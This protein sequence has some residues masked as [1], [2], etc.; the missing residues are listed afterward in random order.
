MKNIK[1]YFVVHKIQGLIAGVILIYAGYYTYGHFTGTS[2]ETRYTT[3][4]AD[5]QTIV[6][7]VTG[8]GQVSALNQ[9]DIKSK[10]SGDVTYIGVTNGQDVY[11]GQII[12]EL[13]S[14]SA[15]KTVR[16]AQASLDSA[17]L[18]LVKIKEPADAL[19]ILQAEN[20]ITTAKQ[21]QGQITN[22]ISKTYDD[23]F[24]TVSAAFID[25]PT[26]VT[27]LQNILYQNTNNAGQDNVSYYSDLVKNYDANV[28][29][30]RSNA[31]TAYQK[32]RQVYDK[33]FLDYKSSTRYADAAT[34]RNLLDETTAT[35]KA[36]ADA[37]KTINDFLNFVKD[38]LTQY[39]AAIPTQLTAHQTSLVTYTDKTNA[40]LASLTNEVNAIT[41]NDNALSSANLTIEEKTQ[42]LIKLQTGSDPLDIQS[43]E[44]S[45]KQRENALQDAKDNLSYYSIRA[46]Y[47]GTVSKMN[48]QKTDQVGNGTVV[49]SMV[50]KQRIAN[51]SLNEIDAAKIS[52]GQKATLTFDAIGGL[53][54]AGQVSSV[55]TVGAVSQGVVTYNVQINFSTQ[56]VRIKP[57]MSVSAAIVTNVKTD[58]IAVPNG[59]VKNQGGNQYVEVFD[60]AMA[61]GTDGQGTPSVTSP[62]QVTV[63]T[64]LSNDTLTEVT[65]GLTGTENVVMRTVTV[66]AT[67]TTAP[68]I[69]NA[70]GGNR[71]GGGGGGPGGG[72]LRGARGG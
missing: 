72:I 44:L 13:D 55:D 56:D 22:N 69:L 49:A 31:E 39:N 19:S 33:N 1:N 28:S 52:L 17:N 64:G 21:S 70:V 50:T 41:G 42:A 7:S 38:K 57:G 30:Y 68:S 48:V 34:I 36:T 53:T 54:I 32:A 27:G 14:T 5:R 65:S 47:D 12:A 59:A 25:L 10:A 18:S 35:T 23:A 66:S 2:G 46:P 11:Q 26:T 43:V 24:T 8:S 58:V 51:I 62:R 15:E 4:T 9:Y 63:Q 3:T 6:I 71:G 60:Q 40:D 29:I 16:D 20:A 37:T 61:R 45:V 67:Q